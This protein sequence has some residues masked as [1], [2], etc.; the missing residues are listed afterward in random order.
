[1]VSRFAY[2]DELAAR[3]ESV[4]R[5]FSHAVTGSKDGAIAIAR[6]RASLS[7]AN[8]LDESTRG[9]DDALYNRQM[10]MTLLCRDM[11]SQSL[12]TASAIVG[13]MADDDTEALARHHLRFVLE[14]LEADARNRVTQQQLDMKRIALLARSMRDSHSWDISATLLRAR[15]SVENRSRVSTD[16]IGRKQRTERFTRLLVRGLGVSILADAVVSMST[17]ESFSVLTFNGELVSRVDRDSYADVRE[18]LFHPQA[19]RYLQP[20]L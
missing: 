17:A 5:T 15:E 9:F 18:S 20:R 16:S 12:A 19:E 8:M 10:L 1:M 6:G 7:L 4:E 11:V 14:R 3:A 2:L 13:V